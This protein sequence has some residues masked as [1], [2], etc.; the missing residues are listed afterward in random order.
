MWMCP[1]SVIV[2]RFRESVGTLNLIHLSVC[3]SVRHKNVNLG[4]NFCTITD[5]ALILGM[6][7]PCYKTFPVVPCRDFD[8]YL[9]PTSRSNLLPSGGPQFSECACLFPL[10][11]RRSEKGRWRQ[12]GGMWRGGRGRGLPP[13][14]P[15][16]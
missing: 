8:G 4:H 13:V 5:S 10:H 3:P 15:L 9:W 2:S 11:L 6:C 7:V 16:M 12:G 1:E 14:H